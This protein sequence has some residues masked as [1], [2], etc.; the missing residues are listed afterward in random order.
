[1]FDLAK[2]PPEFKFSKGRWY[3]FKD[4]DWSHNLYHLCNKESQDLNGVEYFVPE[5][6]NKSRRSSPRWM[7]LNCV[8]KAPDSIV[9]VFCL[10]EPDRSSSMVQEALREAD[11]GVGIWE[12]KVSTK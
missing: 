9:T 4:E 11:R 7:C 10:L 6:I 2:E 3:I 5:Q 8:K 12:T 1:M